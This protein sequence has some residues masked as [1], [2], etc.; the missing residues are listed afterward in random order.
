MEDRVD[1]KEKGDEGDGTDDKNGETEANID[2][3]GLIFPVV[4]KKFG[5]LGWEG[6]EFASFGM[7]VGDEADARKEGDGDARLVIDIGFLEFPV[8]PPFPIV[9]DTFVFPEVFIGGLEFPQMVPA[10]TGEE[11]RG[12]EGETNGS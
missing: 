4:L 7:S 10:K 6:D 2:E 11:K 5:L 1:E 8:A 12:K 3:L 9:T